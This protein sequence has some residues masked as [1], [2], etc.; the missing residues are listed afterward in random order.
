VAAQV[1]QGVTPV[2]RAANRNN[3]TT[4]TVTTQQ[5]SDE[6]EELSVEADGEVE[7]AEVSTTTAEE[8]A[9]PLQNTALESP[10]E[11]KSALPIVAVVLVAVAGVGIAGFIRF[12]NV[13]K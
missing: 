12:R 4:T 6:E 3:N 11:S 8:A 5:D 2:V 13:V 7:T 9:A 10:K 1:N